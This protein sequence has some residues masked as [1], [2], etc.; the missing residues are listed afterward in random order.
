LRYDQPLSQKKAEEIQDGGSNEDDRK[1]RFRRTASEI[2]RHYRCPVETCQ[3]S[4]GSEG[5]LN[6][7]VKLKH[8]EVYQTMP[9]ISQS[10]E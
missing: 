8:F 9:H 5:S 10:K 3:K 4:Y 1:K 7:H 2:E 6:Q